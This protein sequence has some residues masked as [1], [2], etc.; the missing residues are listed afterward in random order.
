MDDS[1]ALILRLLDPSSFALCGGLGD[2]TWI[3][4]WAWTMIL[5]WLIRGS[6]HHELIGSLTTC[7]GYAGLC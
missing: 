6:W 4:V 3:C 2:T 7:R 5:I 1:I